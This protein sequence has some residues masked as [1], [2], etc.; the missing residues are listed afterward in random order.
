MP[1]QQTDALYQLIKTLSRA[2]K[3]HFKVYVSRTQ[4]S[5]N[6]KF[7]QLF[8]VLDK[9]KSYDES[10]ISDKAPEI[11]RV[12]IPNL[13]SHL[14]KQILLSLRLQHFHHNIDME[15]RQQL[16]YAKLLYNKGLYMQSL[17][18]LDKTKTTAMEAQQN[19]LCVE[20]IEF[21]KLI[22]SQY[23]TR[24]I[25]GRAEQLTKES[26]QIDEVIYRSNRLSDLALQLYGLYIK[27]GHIR[28]EE[29]E[30]EVETFFEEQ[31]AQI[32][33]ANSCELSF[34]EKLHLY[35]SYVWYFYIL[36][37]FP[38]CYRYADK[39]VN[40]FLKNPIMIELEPFHYVKGLNNLL[41]ALYNTR[42][43][44]KFVEVLQLLKEFGE[45]D[46]VKRNE[47][48]EI[49]VFLF[50]SIHRINKHFLEGTFTEA[51]EL[52]PAI[53]ANIKKLGRKLDKHRILV[54]YYK[55]ACIY[56]ASDDYDTAIDYLNEIVNQGNVQ[57]REDIH[58]FA[59]ILLLISHFELEHNTLIESQV[60]STYRFLKKMNDFH[61]MQEAILQF[62]RRLPKIFP[63][64][65]QDGFVTLHKTLVDLSDVPYEKRTFLYFDIISWLESKI[66][67]RPVEEVIRGKFLK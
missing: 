28:N 50:T 66:E 31:L 27:M 25:E 19:M 21:E 22:E 37:N 13:K 41:A 9:M 6:A 54:F 43:Y 47:N 2:E 62:L 67:G 1:N 34:Y 57:L 64:Q 23:I 51:K 35:R 52:V 44:T 36:Q 39:W 49:Q 48:I 4:S 8:D 42:Y 45:H 55:I 29:D 26:R 30:K 60:K 38:Y 16:D 12:Q 3:R 11:K 10:K 53:E 32:E 65:L 63:N 15:I 40:L 46:V 61:G 56:F 20:I 17:K 7:I 33:G 14:Y 24:S 18:L 58:C 59:R 5:E